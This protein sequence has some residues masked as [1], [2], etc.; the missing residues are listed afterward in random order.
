KA[1]M[2]GVCGC[3][4]PTLNGSLTAVNERAIRHDVRLE[5]Q[6]G[7]WGTLLVSECGTT[8]DEMRRVIDVGVDEARKVGLRTVLLASF[9]TL[10]KVVEM[11]RYGERAGVDLVLISYPLMFYP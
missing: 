5:K 4:L 2:R 10:A 8:D 3:M 6:L 7:F 11:V 9:P 1:N